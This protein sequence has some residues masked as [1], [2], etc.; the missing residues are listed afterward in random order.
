LEAQEWKRGRE[1]MGEWEKREG[2]EGVE[3]LVEGGGR[4][5]KER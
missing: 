4:K 2:E 1:G 5:I 3:E